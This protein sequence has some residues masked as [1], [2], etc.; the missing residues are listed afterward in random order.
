MA[1]DIYHYIDDEWEMIDVNSL[2]RHALAA[3][4][5]HCKSKKVRN[6]LWTWSGASASSS[7]DFPWPPNPLPRCAAGTAV[8]SSRRCA[9][10]LGA[11]ARQSIHRED[12]ADIGIG[13]RPATP[14]TERR[15]LLCSMPDRAAPRPAGAMSGRRIYRQETRQE[16]LPL[17]SRRQDNAAERVAFPALQYFLQEVSLKLE[18][19]SSEMFVCVP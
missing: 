15:R 7:A 12:A 11:P 18:S 8:S 2:C 6:S 5:R 19:P 3:H 17:S 13:P 10:Q 9:S 14:S 4:P 1:E 16:T